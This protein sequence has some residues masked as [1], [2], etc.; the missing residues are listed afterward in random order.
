MPLRLFLIFIFG[1]STTIKAA[2]LF[3][4][5]LN[6]RAQAMGG[7][8]VGYV[9]GVDALFFNPAALAQVEGYSLLIANANVAASQNS[10]RLLDQ[11][12][13][14]GQALNSGQLT[15]LYGNTYFAEVSA[16]SGM[17]F[18]S[19][20]FGVFSNNH[21]VEVFNNPV[22]PTFHVDFTSDYGYIVA[23]AI[24]FSKEFS[25]GLAG[26]HVVRWAGSKDVLVSDLIGSTEQQIIEQNFPDKGVG[27][28]LDVSAL[29]LLPNSNL[30][31][32]AVWKDVGDT[33]FKTSA[34]AG[35]ENQENNL[36]IGLAHQKSMGLIDLTTALDYSFI[37]QN[38]QL[39]KK[40]H[41]GTELSLGLIDLRAGFNQGYLTYGLG[42]DLKILQID[43]NAYSQE[44][45]QTL[46]DNKNDRYQA[47]ISI[48]LDFDKSFK[49]K[50]SDGKKR[51]LMQRR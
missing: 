46:G 4:S 14:Q 34:G 11:M 43:L 26:R 47:S 27:N 19:F 1:I 28:A 20:G 51:R 29:W 41:L 18:P 3:Q 33:S 42:I 44:V 30:S 24:P 21:V 32:A 48:L 25:I 36:T 49:I 45:G 12:N 39:V 37:R 15:E 2:G 40:L 35:V 6:S 23:G 50:T 7:A 38:D 16:Y 17:V 8:H 5:G 13:N 22:Y 9:R 31:I 10:Q